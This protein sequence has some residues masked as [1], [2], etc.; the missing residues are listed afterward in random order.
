MFR[1]LFA[2]E[3]QEEPQHL[4]VAGVKLFVVTLHVHWHSHFPLGVVERDISQRHLLGSCE[5]QFLH[6]IKRIERDK[7]GIQLL[8][9]IEGCHISAK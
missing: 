2:E 3:R 9:L 4:V 5:K 7:R 6:P 1:R 8:E